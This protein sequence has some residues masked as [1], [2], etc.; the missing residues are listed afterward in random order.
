MDQVEETCA[1][2]QF[3]LSTRVGADCVGHVIRTVTERQPDL[4]VLS[5]DGIGAYDHVYRISIMTKLHEVPGLRKLLPFVWRAHSRPSR[6]SWVD[7]PRRVALDSATRGRGTGGPSCA[8][9]EQARYPRCTLRSVWVAGG[10]AFVR[11]L[12]RCICRFQ[13]RSHEVSVR[14][15]GEQVACIGRNRTPRGQNARVEPSRRMPVWNGCP[16]R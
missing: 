2:F 8:P 13:T 9:F 10:R 12:G 5:V 7:G 14:S 1:P 11:V 3:A 6:Y 4:T 15:V 16:W